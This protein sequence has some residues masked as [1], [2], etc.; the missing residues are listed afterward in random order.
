MLE[1]ETE[2]PVLATE[3]GYSRKLFLDTA[4][5]LT[6]SGKR[7]RTRSLIA[8]LRGPLGMAPD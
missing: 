4:Y 8:A 5:H 6:L 7:A 1:R 3:R 2:I